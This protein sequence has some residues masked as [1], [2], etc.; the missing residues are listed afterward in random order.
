MAEKRTRATP[1]AEQRA[2]AVTPSPGRLLTSGRLTRDTTGL[3]FMGPYAVIAPSDPSDGWRRLQLDSKTLDRVPASKLAEYLADLSPEVSKALWDFLRECNPGYQITALRPGTEEEDPRAQAALDD[4]LASLGE[5]Y[6]TLDVVIGRL[7]L[8]LFLRGAFLAELILDAAGR[9]P[10]DLATP[11][12]WSIRFRTV[13]DPVRGPVWQ[14]VQW[15]GGSAPVPL[16]RPTIRYV[17]VDPFPTSPYGRPLVSP[18][19]FIS[20]FL[21]AM[22]HDLRRVV[23]QQGYPRIDLEID[24][25]AIRAALPNL[26][27][28]D[29]TTYMQAAVDQIQSGYAALEPD[30]A[31]IHVNW[32]KVNKPVGTVDATSL[33]GIGAV[34]DTLERMVVKALKTTP[35]LQALNAATSE[36]TANREWEA[37]LQS[38]KAIQ[39]YVETPLG[40]LF[41]LALQ[42][43]GIAATVRVEFAEN[44]ASEMQRDALTEQTRIANA[45]A[46]YDNGWLSH[47]EA[48]Q[49][50]TGHAADVPEPRGVTDGTPT[51][52]D[53]EHNP[54]PGSDRVA[55]STGHAA[56]HRAPEPATN[57]AARG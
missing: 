12:P 44:R 48:A 52:V 25:A 3:P 10:I 35:L 37:H 30:D 50:V 42:V 6:G 49:E 24:Q 26:S 9:V 4:F 15:Q 27:D 41:A 1:K 55:P 19:L 33:G 32:V 47:D 20:L 56:D 46:K 17:P 8:G 39:H 40:K 57:G 53:P 28:A 36:A 5:V 11:D 29:F 16:D 23:Q 13:V 22:L 14:L 21:L 34:I 54:D 18:A 43:Q 7:F 51:A 45:R 38:I 2:P 31:Y